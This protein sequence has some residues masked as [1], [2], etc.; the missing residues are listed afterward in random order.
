MATGIPYGSTCALVANS[1][2]ELGG[3]ASAAQEEHRCPSIHK[4]AF[5]SGTLDGP[6]GCVGLRASLVLE[7]DARTPSRQA[8]RI[9]L[10]VAQMRRSKDSMAIEWRKAGLIG[11]QTGRAPLGRRQLQH[12]APARKH[13][14]HAGEVG[15]HCREAEQH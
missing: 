15:N 8:L 7:T 5:F 10:S 3:K 14:R 4:L 9:Y 13:G 6:A 2:T 12:R 11:G 1:A